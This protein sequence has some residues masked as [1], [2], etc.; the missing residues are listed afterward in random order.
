MRSLLIRGVLA[1][2][3]VVVLF[4]SACR[5]QARSEERRLEAV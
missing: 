2:A 3:L 5:W 1:I 4:L